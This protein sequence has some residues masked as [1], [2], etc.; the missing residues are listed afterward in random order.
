MGESS[1]VTAA[2]KHKDSPVVTPIMSFVGVD[3]L[4]FSV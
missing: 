2:S 3:K 1:F 4:S